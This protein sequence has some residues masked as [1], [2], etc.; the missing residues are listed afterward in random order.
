MTK[1]NSF[2]VVGV[3]NL[4]EESYRNITKHTHIDKKS[5]EKQA[6]RGNLHKL[7]YINDNISCLKIGDTVTVPYGKSSHRLGR[8][9]SINIPKK[10]VVENFGDKFDDI[11]FKPIDKRL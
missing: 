4:T 2:V 6:F 10:E 5:I 8:V 9:V 7:H 1:E 11:K 3:S